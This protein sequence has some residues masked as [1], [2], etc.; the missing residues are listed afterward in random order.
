MPMCAALI[1]GRVVDAVA[2]HRHHVALLL[3]RVDEQHLVLGRD[4]ADDADLV[5]P[6]QPLGLVERG[7]LRAEDRLARR[8]RAA[9]AIAAPV[10]TSSPVT[11]RT[12]MCAL[13]ASA[14]RRLGLRA[15]R[16]DH[17]DEARHLEALDVAEQV[18]VGVERA[19]VEVA[20]GGGHDAQAGLAHP[21]H[22]RL[23]ATAQIRRPTGRPAPRTARST[24]GSSPPAPRP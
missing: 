18:A 16:V 24:R 5:D 21:A 14:H 12:R 8:S 4:P 13:C 9:S 7:E 3:E 10:M 11:I 20:V 1:D 15:G 6:R 22:A 23:C 17:A 19:G 2:G